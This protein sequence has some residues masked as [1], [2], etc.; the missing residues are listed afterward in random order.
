MR[1]RGGKGQ[2]VG[3]RTNRNTMPRSNV[4]PTTEAA[5]EWAV[6]DDGAGGGRWPVSLPRTTA[7]PMATP[8]PQG[9]GG[10]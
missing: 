2:R 9:H 6:A 3:R 4:L 1:A 10:P 8:L 7:G 5:E